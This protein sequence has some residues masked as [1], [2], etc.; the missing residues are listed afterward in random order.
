MILCMFL[1]FVQKGLSLLQGPAPVAEATN[2]K[3]WILLWG[4]QVSK[5]NYETELDNLAID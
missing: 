5:I 1:F 2:A 4:T 3:I